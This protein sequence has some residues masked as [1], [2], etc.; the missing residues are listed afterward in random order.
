MCPGPVG[1]RVCFCL[2]VFFLRNELPREQHNETKT[3]VHLCTIK[4]TFFSAL[5]DTLMDAFIHQKLLGFN[6]SWEICLLS[7][8]TTTRTLH[9]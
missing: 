2:F 5:F 6:S 4:H 1:I 3:T 9:F 8:L 7:I